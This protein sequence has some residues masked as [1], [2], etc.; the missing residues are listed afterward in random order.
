VENGMQDDI[1]WNDSEQSGKGAPSSEYKSAT[2]GSMD[3]LPDYIKKIE[4]NV[5]V[6]KILNF[7]FILVKR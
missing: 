4:W 7:H 2:E 3:K 1:L 6:V 5:H